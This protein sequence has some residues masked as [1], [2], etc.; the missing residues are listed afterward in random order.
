MFDFGVWFCVGVLVGGDIVCEWGGG[1]VV[2]L[3][4]EC[5]EV[6]FENCFLLLFIL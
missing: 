4:L 1:I 2:F 6:L 3:E 5:Y